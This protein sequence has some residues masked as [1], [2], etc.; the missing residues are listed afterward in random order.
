M[1]I[2]S[3]FITVR[4]LAL[5]SL[6][7]LIPV[8]LSYVLSLRTLDS[9]AIQMARIKGETAFHLIQ[10]T[11]LWNASHKGVYVP[12]T[13]NTPAN[14]YLEAKERDITSAS[15]T[16]LTLVNPAYMTRQLGDLLK[17]SQVEIHLTSLKPLN[18]LN[19]ADLWEQD[20]LKSFEQGQTTAI[21][22]QD[23]Q[24]R[25]MQPLFVEK[26]CLECHEEQGYKE[27][28]VRGGLSISFPRE[29]IEKLLQN[30]KAES[31]QAH[32]IAYSLVWLMG[33]ALTF[34]IRGLRQNLDSATEK[35][36]EL[37]QLAMKDDLT[38]L[39]NRRSIL[40]EY[41]LAYDTSQKTH[42]PLSVLMLDIDHFKQVNDQH[43]HQLGDLVLKEFANTLH[44]TLRDS[45]LSGRYGGEEFIIVLNNGEKA[46]L[47][48]A[49]R[50][51][52]AVESLQFQGQEPFQISVSIGIAE[53]NLNQPD[54]SQHLIRL[55]DD[56][57]YQAKENGR[58]Q[59]ILAKK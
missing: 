53:R 37:N 42:S 55:A 22:F 3:S 6:I 26:P 54:D 1:S 28:D 59:V 35:Q 15:G 25:Y 31:Q 57:L 45:D 20:A 49:E 8:L 47:H 4:S 46:A 36:S 11:R 16:K 19:K 38:G 52:L 29:D 56:A 51:R 41:Q 13:L 39:N 33:M 34:V 9:T 30:L 23:N 10:T 21:T 18:G 24:Y 17:N 5:L 58:N 50:I 40:T 48:V 12:E 14:P 2:P 7:S 32:L 27:G 44:Q 43:G